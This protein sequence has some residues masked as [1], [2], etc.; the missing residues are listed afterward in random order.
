MPSKNKKQLNLFLLVK[1]FKENGEIGVKRQLK[2]LE[3]YKPRLTAK[4]MEKLAKT[5]LSI[6]SADLIDMTSGI[7]GDNPLGDVKELKAG[8]WALFRGK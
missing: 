8:Y 4:Y 7:K 1:A 5:A 6:T 3:G 2:H